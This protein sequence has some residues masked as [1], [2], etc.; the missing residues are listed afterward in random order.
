MANLS[1]FIL[2]ANT[3]V[4]DLI[5]IRGSF[6]STR[7]ESQKNVLQ[8]SLYHRHDSQH[9]VHP[10]WL[11]KNC[12]KF[13]PL[14]VIDWFKERTVTQSLTLKSLLGKSLLEA[15]RKGFFTTEET[16]RCGFSFSTGRFLSRCD[17]STTVAILRPWGELGWECDQHRAGTESRES[18]KS[19]VRAKTFYP[20]LSTTRRNSFLTSEASPCWTFCSLYSQASYLIHYLYMTH[21]RPNTHIPSLWNTSMS[22][23]GGLSKLTSDLILISWNPKWAEEKRRQWYVQLY[24]RNTYCWF[25]SHG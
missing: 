8:P 15:S 2:P 20:G 3:K 17:P 24:K 22:S 9:S 6:P 16:Q 21:I 18:Q 7:L 25:P 19:K 4:G 12:G 23:H 13:V 11:I 5:T 10:K 1:K 14:S